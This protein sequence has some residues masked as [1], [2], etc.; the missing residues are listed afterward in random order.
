VIGAAHGDGSPGGDARQHHQR[1]VEQGGQHE[2]HRGD[3]GGDVAR[4]EAERQDG[5]GQDEAE[6]Q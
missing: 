1:G 3:A 5:R 2:Q 6:E 4:W